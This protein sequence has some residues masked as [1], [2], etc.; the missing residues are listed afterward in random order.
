MTRNSCPHGKQRK[1][2]CAECQK[3]YMR[4]WYQ[5]LRQDPERYARRR[6]AVNAQRRGKGYGPTK[7]IAAEE[8]RIGQ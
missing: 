6:D 8:G 1:K 5:A 3:A 4:D 2:W 7:A